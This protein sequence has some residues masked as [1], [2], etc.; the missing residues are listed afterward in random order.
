MGHTGESYLVDN[1][2][3]L[4]SATRFA[5]VAEKTELRS[6]GVLEALGG[7]TATG[8]YTDYRKQKVLGAYAPIIC[9]GQRWAILVEIDYSEA[10]TGLK[11]SGR[12]VLLLSLLVFVAMGVLVWI[13][14]RSLSRPVLRL[15]KAVKEVGKGDFNV[16]ISETTND[17]LGELTHSF[18]EMS[19]KLRLM[20]EE[21]SRQRR[22]RFS[23][24]IDGQEQ[25]R[26]RLSRELHDGLGQ[27]LIAVRLRLE[28][29][30]AFEEMEAEHLLEQAKGMIDRAVD[31]VRDI[32]NNLIPPGLREFGFI[33]ALSGLCRELSLPG[34]FSISFESFGTDHS[35]NTRLQTYLYRIAQ[36]ALSNAIK[37]SDASHIQLSISSTPHALSL[38]VQDNGKGFIF[39]KVISER[40]NG[41]YNMRERARVLGGEFSVVSAPGK[42]ARIWVYVP[43][44]REILV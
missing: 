36:E 8:I 18:N 23:A 34:S 22:S 26:Q 27:L 2:R 20:S 1:Y 4:R 33:S 30:P 24:F 11:A 13:L 12:T 40:G 15:Q 31:D 43:L 38:V 29:L 41:L 25:E 6:K 28:G 5:G 44:N 17:E 7:K 32:S 37:H 21:I 35:L 14:S 9:D 16:H 42:G 3:H 10:I 19:E 39:D